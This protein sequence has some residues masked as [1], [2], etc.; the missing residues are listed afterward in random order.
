MVFFRDKANSEFSISQPNDFLSDRALQRRTRQSIPIETTDLP[1][2]RSY[3]E[4]LKLLGVETFYTTKW[5]NGVLVQMTQDEASSVSALAYVDRIEYVA[6]NAPLLNI[7]SENSEGPV[8]PQEDLAFPQN[9]LLG[10]PDMHRE[11][12]KGENILIG[13]FDD[14]FQNLSSI[15]YFNHLFTNN[16]IV[17]TFDFV[18][19]RESVENGF[20]HGTRA[21]SLIAALGPDFT[22]TAPNASFIL[23]VTEDD[24]SEYRIEEYNWLFAAEKADSLGVDI[25][26]TS[27]GYS[28]FFNDLQMNYSPEQMNGDIAVISRASNLAASKGIMLVTSA[29]NNGSLRWRIVTAPADSEQV[30]AVGAALFNGELA[31]FSSDGPNASGFTK[32]DVVAIGFSTSL[33]GGNGSPTLQG[34]TSFSAPQVTGLAA[35]LWQAFPNLTQIEL[36]DLIRRSGDRASNPDNEF[37]YGFPNW[38]RAVELL[39]INNVDSEIQFSLFPNPT[40]NNEVYLSVNEENISNLVDIQLISSLGEV[41]YKATSRV[42]GARNSVRVPLNNLPSGIYLVRLSNSSGSRTQ[43]LIKY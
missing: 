19:N 38:V 14:G 41:V 42:F 7:T 29:G 33:I 13:V 43:R 3:V 25:I 20:N 35:G 34:G 22:G 27:L 17:N 1:V 16:R 9:Q 30:L 12:F 4:G 5:M 31:S 39:S 2:N 18:R 28:N 37:G 8:T 10:I 21:L 26:S 23:A 32:P 24:R 40:S 36:L 11:G 15:F 6:P